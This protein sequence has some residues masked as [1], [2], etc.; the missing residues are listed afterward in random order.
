MDALPPDDPSAR[1]RHCDRRTDLIQ[2]DGPVVVCG[3]CLLSL[4]QLANDPEGAP[5]DVLTTMIRRHG[6]VVHPIRVGRPPRLVW[7]WI[8]WP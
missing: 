5:S 7:E 6:E 3:S 2:H 4:G 8:G 1:C